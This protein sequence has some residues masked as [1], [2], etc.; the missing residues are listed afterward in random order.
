[1]TDVQLYFAIGVPS[2]V[3][4]VNA[5]AVLVGILINSSRLTDLRIGID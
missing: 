3:I 1:M 2:L 4:A 5:L